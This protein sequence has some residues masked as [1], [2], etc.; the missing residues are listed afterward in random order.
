MTNCWSQP[1]P[2]ADLRYSH[3]PRLFR[4]FFLG[5]TLFGLIIGRLSCMDVRGAG[6]GLVIH[7][8]HRCARARSFRLP[9]FRSGYGGSALDGVA[10][11]VFPD[12]NY[13]ARV[14]PGARGVVMG[15]RPNSLIGSSA[16]GEA[17]PVLYLVLV[18]TGQCAPQQRWPIAVFTRPPTG[19]PVLRHG[20]APATAPHSIPRP[21][22]KH[23]GHQV[24]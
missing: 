3:R 4:E 21:P 17:F 7:R 8:V 22:K 19:R 1:A 23:R 12:L 2:A 24:P 14:A 20:C 16:L 5:G 11:R 18:V 9:R 15:M 10:L 6:R 13:R